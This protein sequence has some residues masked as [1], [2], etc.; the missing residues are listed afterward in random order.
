[1]AKKM[2]GG[3]QN[4]G[5]Q[6]TPDNVTA[7]SNSAERLAMIRSGALKFCQEQDEIDRMHATHVKPLKD[8][9]AKAVKKLATDLGMTVTDMKAEF[10]RLRRLI[11]AETFEDDAEKGKV[12]DTVSELRRA[13]F[14]EEAEIDYAALWARIYNDADEAN[15]VTP[16]AAAKGSSA[17]APTHPAGTA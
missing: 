2:R 17:P 1:M 13:L 11:V 12:H 14:G 3:G 5:G 10:K 6:E 15:G 8:A 7:L 4:G 16:A 9:Q